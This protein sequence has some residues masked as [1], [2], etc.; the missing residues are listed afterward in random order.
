MKKV[1][2]IFLFCF[3]ASYFLG[4]EACWYY[5]DQ[6]MCLEVSATKLLVK[7]KKPE[8]DDI[9]DAIENMHVGNLKEI[10]DMDGLFYIEMQQTSKE[11]IL[12]L[13][14]QLNIIED[15]IY[16]SRVFWDERGIEGTSYAN[17][18]KVRLKSKEDFPVLQKNAENYQIK[19][20][21]IY[22][23]DELQY[24]LTLPH[25]PQQD[26]MDVA[27]ELHETGLF[28]YAVPELITLWPLDIP[29]AVPYIKHEKSRIYPNPAY[30]MLS[31][32]IARTQ[33][34]S[35][36]YYEIL[37]FNSQ[38]NLLRRA[39]AKENIVQ[40]DVSVLPNGIYF[41]HISDGISA[42]SETYKVIV[43]H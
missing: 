10:V 30:D 23:F 29:N 33:N 14:R 35:T 22:E 16:A 3:V 39:H 18:I 20:I 42:T 38:G 19:D 28:E 24:F 9:K 34:N 36:V 40:F 13:Q 26:A 5:L 8:K 27:L 12:E 25:N 32:E 2:N 41:L 37:L 6:K 15:I 43:K 21:T 31:I 17:E 7:S 1:I 4:Q 11:D